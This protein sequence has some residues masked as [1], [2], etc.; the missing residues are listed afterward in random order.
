MP[1]TSRTTIQRP[2][3]E[4]VVNLKSAK[5][6][7]ERANGIVCV[8]VG[9]RGPHLDDVLTAR[10]KIGWFEIHPENY[11]GGGPALTKLD[12][13]RRHYEVSLHGVGLSI[14][15][16]EGMDRDHLRRLSTLIR[17]V[18]PLLVSEHL[19]WS[20][21][22]RTYLN[23]LLPL[24]YTEETLDIVA[25]NVEAAQDA[26]GRPIAVENP[27]TYL[28]FRHSTI[29][30]AEFL[31]EVAQRTGCRILCD[32]NNI[33]VSCVNLGLSAHA[34]LDALPSECV[35]EVHLAGHSRL[36]AAEQTIL[37]DDHGSHIGP[38]VLNLYRCALARFGPIPTLVEWDTR[39]PALTVL[40]AEARRVEAVARSALATHAGP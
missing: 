39:I 12:A 30:E 33:H 14:G 24:P 17:R 2:A 9:L 38:S 34:Y 37:I 1:S 11:F 28:R 23:D 26:L 19:A 18:D 16:T 10:S 25:T 21:V 20:V 3:S 13:I 36:K 22:D 7:L 5:R 29:P 15:S 31:R 40:L 32:V 35:A 6:L 27:S 4:S 8:G